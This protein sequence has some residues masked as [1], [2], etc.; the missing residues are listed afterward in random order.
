MSVVSY[1]VQTESGAGAGEGVGGAGAV[2]LVV[3]VLAVR[4]AVAARAEWD[5]R[6][7]RAV[8]RVG[9]ARRVVRPVTCATITVRL[10]YHYCIPS[11]AR[12]FLTP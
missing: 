10:H 8:E 7:A 2:G 6:A 1:S 12:T 3:R 5:A 11:Q 9:A 4:G